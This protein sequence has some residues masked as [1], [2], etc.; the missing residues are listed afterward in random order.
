MSEKVCALGDEKERQDEHTQSRATK[1][2]PSQASTRRFVLVRSDH[3]QT[4]E[5][6]IYPELCVQR[7]KSKET[8]LCC[9][10]HYRHWN[11][12]NH[13]TPPVLFETKPTSNSFHI[14]RIYD[15]SIPYP[16]HY[17][18]DFPSDTAFITTAAA[19][20]SASAARAR[21]ASCSQEPRANPHSYLRANGVLR[22]RQSRRHMQSTKTKS[23]RQQEERSINK[24]ARHEGGQREWRQLVG[25][26][27]TSRFRERGGQ[28]EASTMTFS[29]GVVPTRDSAGR[30]PN[31]RVLFEI[32]SDFTGSEVPL[33]VHPLQEV[34]DDDDEGGLIEENDKVPAEERG[35]DPDKDSEAFQVSAHTFEH[36]QAKVRKYDVRRDRGIKLSPLDMTIGGG[37][38]KADHQALQLICVR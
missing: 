4:P 5:F 6:W 30:Y 22:L 1:A 14:L 20:T 7:A 15:L 29:R 27:G 31:N 36:K 33:R 2:E 23:E 38:V 37:R 32:E 8:Q 10:Q 19:R 11:M 17:S 12:D 9:D 28:G 16:Q 35:A 24:I 25:P 26:D 13:P 21:P 34:W 18:H 3:C